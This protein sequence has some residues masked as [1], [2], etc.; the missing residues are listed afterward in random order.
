MKTKRNS[1]ITFLGVVCIVYWLVDFIFNALIPH[2]FSWLLWYSSAGLL[3]TGIA[4]LLQNNILIY[5][6]FCALFIPELTWIIDFVGKFLFHKSLFGFTFYLNGLDFAG[7]SLYL[8]L[9]HFLIPASLLFAIYHSKK[10]FIYGWLGALVFGSIIAFLT[11]T[12]VGQHDQVNC[13]QSL[14]PCKTVF[15]FLYAIPNP[16]R[17]FTTLFFLVI[18]IYIPTNFIILKFKKK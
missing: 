6:L 7:K 1:F 13:M 10:I 12:F 8:T 15:S 2:H 14:S 9:Y 17:I 11:Y 16:Q 4:L 5:S 18:F 3:L